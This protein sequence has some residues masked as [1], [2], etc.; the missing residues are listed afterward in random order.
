MWAQNSLWITTLKLKTITRMD[1]G[2]KVLHSF[3]VT[4]GRAHGLGW[5]GEAIWCMFSNDLVIHRLDP[6][7]GLILEAVQL[8]KSDPDPHGMTWHKGSLYYTDAGIA[9]GG[10]DNNSRYAGYICR[11]LL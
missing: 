5:D 4:L 1:G 3:P 9:P 10:V 7:D 11:I 2:G 6:K 8:S